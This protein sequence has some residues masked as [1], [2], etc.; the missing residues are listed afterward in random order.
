MFLAYK[1]AIDASKKD[2][3]PSDLAIFTTALP[4]DQP[5][6]TQTDGHTHI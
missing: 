4:I 5:M 1:Y 6:D 3:S 2:E